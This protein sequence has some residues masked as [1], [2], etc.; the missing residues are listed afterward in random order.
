MSDSSVPGNNGLESSTGRCSRG[1]ELAAHF[2]PTWGVRI[3]ADGHW[4]EKPEAQDLPAAET[5]LTLLVGPDEAAKLRKALRKEKKLNHYAARDL[6]R[7]SGLPLLDTDDSEVAT[8]LEK[9][10]VGKKLSPVL[11]V[12]GTPLWIADGYHRICASYHVD[13]KA[14]VACR[15]VARHSG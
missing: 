14:M 15:V 9:I 2:W 3:V 5:Y 10:K 6:L 7:A 1:L 11:L 4:M 8:D 13:E 12:Q